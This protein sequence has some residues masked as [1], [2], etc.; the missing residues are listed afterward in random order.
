MGLRFDSTFWSHTYTDTDLYYW[1]V[2]CKF[3]ILISTLLLVSTAKSFTWWTISHFNDDASFRKSA[4]LIPHSTQPPPPLHIHSPFS[5]HSSWLALSTRWQ[6]KNFSGGHTEQITHLIYT[7]LF[8][9]LFSYCLCTSF[10]HSIIH[11]A[12]SK[13]R[14]KIHT[15]WIMWK[16]VVHAKCHDLTALFQVYLF[17][18]EKWYGGCKWW[19]RRDVEGRDN[20]VLWSTVPESDCTEWRKTRNLNQETGSGAENRTLTSDPS[21]NTSLSW[22]CS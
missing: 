1:F 16:E 2:S 8:K 7:H 13:R 19:I 14:V 6:C 5:M 3:P 4:P 12:V 10:V 18:S 22:Y 9:I 17:C 15:G 20:D 21:M 11:N